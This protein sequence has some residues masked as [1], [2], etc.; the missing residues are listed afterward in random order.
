MPEVR[1]SD[2]FPAARDA[3]APLEKCRKVLLRVALVLLPVLLDETFQDAKKVF[4]RVEVGRVRRQELQLHACAVA[5]L[6]DAIAVVERRVVHDQHRLRF[7]LSAAVLKQLL[8]EILKDVAVSQSLEHAREKYAVLCVC[9]QDLVP[10][11]SMKLRDLHRRNTKRGPA[12][13]PE[14]DALVTSGLIYVDKVVR[15][16]GGHVMQVVILEI[17]ISLFCNLATCFLRPAY[18]LQSAT[19][20]GDVEQHIE[21]VVQKHHH[22]VLVHARLL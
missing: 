12:S 15:K 11:A 13:A 22:L 21:L 14:A 2:V 10:T 5:Q 17:C 19:H 4:D 9:W 1:F 7:W 16:I 20:H 18:R 8:D 3:D 6:P